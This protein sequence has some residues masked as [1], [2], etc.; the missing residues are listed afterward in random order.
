VVPLDASCLLEPSTAML[1]EGPR[2]LASAD[3]AIAAKAGAP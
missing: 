3:A 1:V 2:A